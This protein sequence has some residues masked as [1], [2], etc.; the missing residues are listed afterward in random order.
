MCN[1]CL[2]T[3]SMQPMSE[4]SL[5]LYRTFR[6]NRKEE[7]TEQCDN[8]ICEKDICKRCLKNIGH[9]GECRFLN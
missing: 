3:P 9:E 4:R 8:S 2:T 6:K 1:D 5:D 7:L